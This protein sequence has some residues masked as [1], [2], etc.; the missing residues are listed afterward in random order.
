MPL[1]SV[2]LDEARMLLNDVA[3]KLYTNTVLLPPLRKA[4]RELQQQLV[5]NGVSVGRDQSAELS[6]AGSVVVL[7]SGST[8]ALPTNLL[9]PIE[10]HEKFTGEDDTEYVKMSER[11][12]PPDVT[13][14]ERRRYWSWLEE[15]IK[16]PEASGI[17]ILRIRYWGSLA[18]II[19]G[20]TNIPILDSETFL[21][22]RTASI[23]AFVLGKAPTIAA[24]LEADAQKALEIL[25]ST[26]VKNRQALPVRRRPFR[27]S[28]LSS[29]FWR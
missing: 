19:D 3:A 2:A 29:I 15:E 9:Y 28:R 20:T 21:G 18:A 14:T 26:S 4:Y 16:F 23:A 8:P 5:D 12:W 17:T 25:L 11:A 10:I 1:A 6:V 7:N 24:S 13:A 27:R 22:A